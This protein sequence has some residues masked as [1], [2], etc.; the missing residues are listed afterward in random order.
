MGKLQL[1]IVTPDRV[2]LRTEADYVSLPGVEGDFGVLPD[3]IPFFAAL[4]IACL[5]YETD[6]KTAWA[7]VTGGFAEI[8]DNHVQVL[9][10][11][12]ELADEIDVNRAEAAFRRAQERLQQARQNSNVNITRAEAALQRALARLQASK[13]K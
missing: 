6:G 5:H 10:D 7:C 8:A 2:V 1:E 9:V 12:A 13:L 11:T 3:H 4:R